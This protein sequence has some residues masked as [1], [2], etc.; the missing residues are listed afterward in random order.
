MNASREANGKGQKA[1]HARMTKGLS[2]VGY[3]SVF[4]LTILSLVLLGCGASEGTAE[5]SSDAQFGEPA[6][7]M[8]SMEEGSFAARAEPPMAD[9]MGGMPAPGAIAEVAA[10]PQPIAA[11]SPTDGQLQ[12]P[13]FEEIQASV[14]AQ[15]RIIIRDV[16]MDLVVSNVIG[17]IDRVSMVAQEFG[18]WTVSSDRSSIHAGSVAIRVPAQELD[19][20]VVDIRSLA[21]RVERESS[22]SQ[23]LTDEYV[24]TNSRLRSLQAT[25][26]ALLGLLNRAVDVEDALDVQRELLELQKEIESMKGRINFLEESSAF[27]LINVHLTLA[28]RPMAVDAGPD[29]TYSAGQ[30]VRFRATFTP[31]EGIDEFNFTWNFGDGNSVSG[32]STAPTAE[33]GQRVTATVTHTYDDDRDSPYIVQLDL[34]GAGPA[35]RVEGSD[36]LI[37]H[38]TRIPT[39]E[40]FIEEYRVV[41]EGEE[42]EYSGSF[43]RGAGLWDLQYI[44]D[45]GDGSPTQI[46][47]PEE[48]ATRATAFHT[49]PDYR[50]QSYTGSLT[51]TA[52]SDAGE[53]RG[54]SSFRVQV[55]QSQGLVVGYWNL[56]DVAKQAVRALTGVASVLVNILIWVAIFSPIWLAIGA[57]VYGL[58]RLRRNRSFRFRRSRNFAR[59]GQLEVE[60]QPVTPESHAEAPRQ[61]NS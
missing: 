18:G 55:T 35:G 11:P 3:R 33:P 6:A 30:L 38:V 15:Q 54:S 58:N 61:E 4:F 47:A 39:I 49:F 48:G 42:V 43:T 25:E 44:W 22:T 34:S 41:E 37:A 53:V 2:M 60:S 40:V 59:G 12:L 23:D 28:P 20:A 8:E 17:A 13:N 46:G 14:S 45:F 56:D 57:L 27:S 29:Q 1:F 16:S 24:D 51:V 36:S 9:A 31:P 10:A 5:W 19:V 21:I 26:E 32:N 7:M 50:P 52:Q